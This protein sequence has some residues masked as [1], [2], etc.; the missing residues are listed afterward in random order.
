M[1]RF[2]SFALSALLLAAP[3][4]NACANV[5]TDWDDLGTKAVQPIPPTPNSFPPNLAYRALAMMHLA[6]FSAVNAI[7]PRYKP[8]KIE[9]SAQPDTSQIAAAAVA[10]ANVLSKVVPSGGAEAALVT[11][12][13]TIPDGAA[14]TNGIKLGEEAAAKVLELCAHDGADTPNAYRPVTQPGVFVPTA[15]TVGWE[16][17]EAT[18]FGL[19]KPAQFRPGPPPDLK[20]EQWAADYNEISSLGEKGSRARTPKQTEDARFWLAAGPV[21]T[22]PIV[23]QIVIGKNMS[24][25]DSTRFLSVV[26]MVEADALIA[27]FDAKYHYNFWRPMTAIR[28]GDIDGNPATERVATWQPIDVTPAHPEYPCAHCIVSQ[29]EAT[30]MTAMLGTADV[31]TVTFSTFTAPRGVVHQW[32]NLDAL[33]DEVSN[34]RIYAGFHYRTSTIVGRDMGRQIGAYIVHNYLQRSN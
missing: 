7:E 9:V 15:F 18:P 25:V 34:A 33:A 11:Y 24:V 4:E 20:S 29:A 28:N 8:Y 14:K 2:V 19:T 12:L 5:I 10:A 32:T 1:S 30:A 16:G 26:S 3:A 31:P 13:A 21:A 27:V 23:R 17:I 22:H 6:M